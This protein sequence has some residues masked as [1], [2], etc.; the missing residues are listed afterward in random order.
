VLY[1]DIGLYD[2][3][4]RRRMTVRID[5]AIQAPSRRLSGSGPWTVCQMPERG[6]TGILT[7]SHLLLTGVP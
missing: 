7:V 5:L 4:L 3:P 1:K 6:I 2:P